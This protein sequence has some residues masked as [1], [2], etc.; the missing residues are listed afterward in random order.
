MY[1][2][3]AVGG[4]ALGDDAVR[5]QFIH[6][7][8]QPGLILSVSVSSY[9]KFQKEFA[10]LHE[11]HVHGTGEENFELRF[12]VNPRHHVCDR[13]ASLR[14]IPDCQNK[15]KIVVRRELM[16]QRKNKLVFAV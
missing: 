8:K 16:S 4:E 6:W 10:G 13:T 1:E 11:D 7:L 15:S 9:I 3:L 12:I 5:P 2:Y 14:R